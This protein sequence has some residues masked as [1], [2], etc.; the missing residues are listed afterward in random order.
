LCRLVA[1]TLCIV[2]RTIFLGFEKQSG[3]GPPSLHILPSISNLIL[4]GKPRG[5][6]ACKEKYLKNETFKIYKNI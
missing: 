5:D 2:C 3:N 4:S 1:L 6:A